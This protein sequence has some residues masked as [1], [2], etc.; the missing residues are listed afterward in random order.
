VA[1]NVEQ[2]NERVAKIVEQN[3]EVCKI[4]NKTTRCKYCLCYSQVWSKFHPHA[5]CADT[6]SPKPDHTRSHDQHS[7]QYTTD[8]TTHNAPLY[9]P[10]SQSQGGATGTQR[11]VTKLR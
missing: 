10:Q 4:L 8:S 5:P 6:K 7:T 3:N 11:T 9:A 1:T 2:N